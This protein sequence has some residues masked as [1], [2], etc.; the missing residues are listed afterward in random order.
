L[1]YKTLQTVLVRSQINN[2]HRPPSTYLVNGLQGD[3]FQ[4]GG[5]KLPLLE[6][7]YGVVYK[8]GSQHVVSDALSRIELQINNSE[9]DSNQAMCA[10]ANHTGFE[11][12]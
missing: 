5:W 12:K 11:F 2:R 10:D 6:Y 9:L 4:V 1:G 3:Q 8:K 7:D